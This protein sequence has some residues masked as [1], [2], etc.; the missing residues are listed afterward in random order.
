[1]KM[2]YIEYDYYYTD[3][4]REHLDQYIDEQME[5][6]KSQAISILK[7][8]APVIH[9]ITSDEFAVIVCNAW[10]S[11]CAVADRLF[12]RHGLDHSTVFAVTDDYENYRKLFMNSNRAEIFN[13]E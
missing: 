1:M 8:Y 5:K 2:N 13:D 4:Y 11:H 9:G 7:M 3:E 12:H 6:E 10:T